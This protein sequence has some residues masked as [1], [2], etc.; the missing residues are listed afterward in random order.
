MKLIFSGCFS[1][2][3]SYHRQSQRHIFVLS[4][5]NNTNTATTNTAIMQFF[6]MKSN[7]RL[8]IFYECAEPP[9]QKTSSI[10]KLSF[11]HWNL[12]HTFYS[13]DELKTPM[14]VRKMH[15]QKQN[16]RMRQKIIKILFLLFNTQ[17]TLKSANWTGSCNN[18][19]KT[20]SKVS[21][22]FV[23]ILFMSHMMLCFFQQRIEIGYRGLFV[24]V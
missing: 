7:S 19:N 3:S 1:N 6:Q 15:E 24:C 14:Y 20:F 10:N 5:P 13:P 11:S 9:G 8:I 2:P 23:F 18:S 21:L 4:K 12:E 16:I 22:T 17:L